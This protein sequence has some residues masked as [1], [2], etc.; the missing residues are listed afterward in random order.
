MRLF[1]TGTVAGGAIGVIMEID[2]T[3]RYSSG[4]T[5]ATVLATNLR[6]AR[7]GMVAG[8][9]PKLWSATGSAVVATNAYGVRHAGYTLGQDVSPAE[10]A[11][12]ELIWT[13]SAGV[14]FLIGPASWLI[15]T[16]VAAGQ[17][18][19]WIWSFKFA[20]FPS[21]WMQE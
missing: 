20:Q 8:V 19:S 7:E 17:A 21:S 16:Y 1:Q 9:T 2:D 18:P 15:Y 6:G 10:G 4:G 13:P 5:V 11:V 3:D 14:D 12:N